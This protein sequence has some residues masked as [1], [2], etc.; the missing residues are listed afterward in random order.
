MSAPPYMKLFWG[1]Y[2]KATRGLTR[3]HHGAYLLLIG[4]AWRL[5]G[6]LPDDDAVLA[7]WAL[8]TDEEWMEMKATIL[9]F[10]VLRRGKW[11]HDRVREEL[12]HYESISRKRKAAGKSGGSASSGKYK[13]NSEAIATQLPTKPEPEPEPEPYKKD[14][15]KSS[16]RTNP[17][18]SRLKA[19]WAP[20][21]TD[22]DFA[23]MLGFK[24]DAIERIAD[25]FRNYWTA[26][27]GQ[28]AL[29][30]DWGATWRNWTLKEAEDHPP[31]L[32][33]GR[34]SPAVL[35]NIQ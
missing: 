35:S 20:S 24:P 27:P 22:R 18:G 2:H 1:D 3:S 14:E 19:D 28:T 23:R 10:F 31:L 12:A 6:S 11:S 32:R 25:I 26:K 15:D 30:L 29:K 17:K 5:G 7:R 8:C 9:A 33:T 21:E 4:E 34:F 13:G 16:S